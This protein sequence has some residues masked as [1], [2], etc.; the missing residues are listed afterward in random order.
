VKGAANLEEPFTPD[1]MVHAWAEP[2][3]TAA[4]WHR[5]QRLARR[6]LNV[7]YTVENQSPRVTS[8]QRLPQGCHPTR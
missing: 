8:G 7:V 2:H 1:A 4:I 5:L 3:G 6:F